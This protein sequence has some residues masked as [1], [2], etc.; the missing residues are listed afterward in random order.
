MD[1]THVFVSVDVEGI[2]GYGG[3]DDA[4][5]SV[6]AAVVADVNAAVDGALDADGDATVTVADS[7]GE[8]RTVPPADLRGRATLVR[9]GPRPQGM[10]DGAAGADLA[11]LIG[12]HDRPGS[13][14]FLEH[15]FTGAIADVRVG[16]QSVGE[17]GLN[18]MLLADLGVPVALVTGDDRLADT[19]ADRL[20]GAAF[21]TTKTVRGSVSVACRPPAAARDDIREAAAAAAADPPDPEPPVALDPPLPVAVEFVR[22]TDADAAALWPGVERGA[23]SRTVRHEARGRPTGS[24]ARRRTSRPTEPQKLKPRRRDAAPWRQTASPSGRSGPC[25]SAPPSPGAGSAGNSTSRPRA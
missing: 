11:F 8:K 4:D 23:D 10:V 3:E 14:G 2:S 12:Y 6:A 21:V 17:T 22:A 20:L 19:V 16:G 1:G 24:S 9:G 7:H 18:A 13:G 15:T 25:P 5:S